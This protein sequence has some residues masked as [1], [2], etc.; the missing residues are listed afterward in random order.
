MSKIW[1]VFPPQTLGPKTTYFGRF[2]TTLQ[3]NNSITAN[4]FE[5]KHVID[6]PGTALNCKGSLYCLKITWTLIHKHRKHLHFNTI[7]KL[8]ILL[9]CQASHMEV[10]KRNS[11]KLRQTA[12]VNRSNKL[13]PT[14][15]ISRS[16]PKKWGQILS[17][18]ARFFRRVWD[19]IANIFLMEHAI[20][21][22]ERRIILLEITF[23]YFP[24]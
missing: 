4:I 15:K 10:S 9:Y 1:T 8:C 19:L 13:P 16:F 18:F 17:I 14:L 3:L 24:M 12:G 6:N 7:R 23:L 5:T 22:R 21:N 2:L 11:T 20:D